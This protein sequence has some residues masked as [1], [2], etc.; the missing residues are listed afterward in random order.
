MKKIFAIICSIL[1][2]LVSS[3]LCQAKT[4]TDEAGR[5]VQVPDDPKRVIAL[6]PSITEIIFDLGQEHRLRGVTQ[7]SNFPE[8]ATQLPR[9]GSYV[10]LDLEKIVS[11]KPDL[12]IAIKDGN[13]I[14]MI[15][16]LESLK[17]PIYAVSPENF[18]SVMDTIRRIGDLLNSHERA[19]SLTENLARRVRHIRSEISGATHHPGVFF[20]I[21]LAPI[22]SAGTDTFIHQLITL[23]GGRNL[24]KGP[25]AYP[26]FS[27][28]QVL[29]LSPEI[30]VITSMAREGG[31]EDVKAEWYSWPHLPAVRNER[32]FIIDSDLVNRPTSRLVAGLE[33]LAELIHPELFK[34]DDKKE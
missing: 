7:F 12:C 32:V 24:A 9:V 2:I 6:A 22:V 25:V 15:R 31:F 18:N 4:V 14:A 10:H 26:R 27:R 21:G 30:I 23:A 19:K 11:L 34:K 5:T 1:F 28:E 16:R 17:I 8:A 20:Q 13:P 29:V 3:T 33:Q